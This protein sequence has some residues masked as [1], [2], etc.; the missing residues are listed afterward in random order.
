[1]ATEE[2]SMA[3]DLSDPEPRSIDLLLDGE[4]LAADFELL[5]GA[6]R[7]IYDAGLVAFLASPNQSAADPG[8]REIQ[9]SL[10]P[11]RPR[12]EHSLTVSGPA[13]EVADAVSWA[14][15][16]ATPATGEEAGLEIP[17]HPPARLPSSAAIDLIQ[18]DL[19]ALAPEAQL[20]V[21]RIE[22][23]SPGVI[24]LEGSG[25]PIKETGKLIER[26]TLLNQKRKAATL[27]NERARQENER[28]RQLDELAIARERIRTVEDFVRLLW[29]DD[30]R[31]VPGIGQL[32]QDVLSG[33]KTLEELMH[34]GQIQLP[35]GEEAA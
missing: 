22:L 14:I 26:M 17:L 9:I 24:S 3:I 12:S 15:L 25:E 32:I 6:V 1:M 8:T 4:W 34:S 16:G 27:A 19:V 29:G 18:G 11:P 5:L 13:E 21:N 31:S 20:R 28:D 33:A 23:S 7:R 35:P 30:F 2:G 10:R